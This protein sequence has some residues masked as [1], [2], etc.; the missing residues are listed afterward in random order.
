MSVLYEDE[1]IRPGN[2]LNLF[3]LINIFVEIEEYIC[4]HYKI[5]LFN[6]MKCICSDQ[7]IYLRRVRFVLRQ[8][9]MWPCD[10]NQWRRRFILRN[11]NNRTG[12]RFRLLYKKATKDKSHLRFWLQDNRLCI[13]GNMTPSPVLQ[14]WFSFYEIW[15]DVSQYWLLPLKP[16]WCACFDLWNL[17]VCSWL[18]VARITL[19]ITLITLKEVKE[20]EAPYSFSRLWVRP[21]PGRDQVELLPMQELNRLSGGLVVQIFSL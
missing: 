11:Y 18:S 8:V 21:S 4:L 9:N 1:S 13:W 6:Q 16:E 19:M 15:R 2:P 20:T 7:E 5:Y 14:I 17:C 10:P 12:D 3:K